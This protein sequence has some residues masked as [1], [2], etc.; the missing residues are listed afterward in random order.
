[1]FQGWENFFMLCGTA[2]ATL[3][4]LLFVVIT[5][6]TNLAPS[7]AA[8]GVHVFVTPTLAHFSGVLFVT[9]IVLAPWG[10]QWAAAS[11]LSLS[12]LASLSHAIW[13]L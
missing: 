4:G 6:G 3:I 11:V 10:S 9:L 5:L 2:A 12:G 13:V 1:M 7:Q 8:P